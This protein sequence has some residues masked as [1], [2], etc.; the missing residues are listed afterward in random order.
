MKP[1]LSALAAGLFGLLVTSVSS[2]EPMDPAIERLVL[3]PGCRT[4]TGEFTGADLDDNGD[5]DKCVPDDVAFKLVNQYGFRVR[6]DGDALRSHHRIRRLSSLD[7]SRVHQD[8]ERRRL[9]G[10]RYPGHSRSPTAIKLRFGTRARSRSCSSTRSSSAKVSAS[11]SSSPASSASCRR[12]AF[13]PAARTCASRCSKAF[14]RAS[15]VFCRTS[16]S[17]AACAPSPAPL[18][19]SSRP[20]ASTRR[21]R[22]RSPSRTPRSSLPG[23]VTSTSSS[24]ATRAWSI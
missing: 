2:A 22:S 13:S 4:A 16:R 18:S 14:A 19:S 7:R 9:L 1:R 23:L 6:A 3:N 5:P 24:S 12:R 15:A 10:E 8:L 21:S 17:A 11:G 20:S